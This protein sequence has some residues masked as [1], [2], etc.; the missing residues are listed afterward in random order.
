MQAG[1]L[2]LV[3]AWVRF[4]PLR[5]ALSPGCWAERG[6]YDSQLL[7]RQPTRGHDYRVFRITVAIGPKKLNFISNSTRSLNSIS[8]ANSLE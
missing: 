6:G 3:F 1:P 7:I 2:A 8:G 5:L 4:A